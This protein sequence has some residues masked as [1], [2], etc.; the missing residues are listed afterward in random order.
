MLRITSI[1]LTI[2]FYLSISS[3]Q[4]FDID[5][6]NL[7]NSLSEPNIITG[8]LNVTT[9]VGDTV[10]LPCE[11][12][13]LGHHHVN[14]LKINGDI[15]L[16]LTVGYQQFSRNMRY[17]VARLHGNDPDRKNRIESW[18]FEIRKVNYEDQGLYQCY[19]KLNPKQ[20]LKASVYLTVKSE[21]E[22]DLDENKADALSYLSSNHKLDNP[23][24]EKLS[25]NLV[26]KVDMSPNSWIK[27]RCN[28]TGSLLLSKNGALNNKHHSNY[29]LHWYKD[30]KLIEQDSR[31]LKKWVSS[32][33]NSNYMELELFAV[34]P[35]DS[36]V[37]QCKR[38]KTILK[39]VILNVLDNSSVSCFKNI[40]F[41]YQILFSFIFYL[42]IL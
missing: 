26:E 13:N 40:N 28:A 23:R 1:L 29:D 21:T 11:V 39:N 6:D 5:T 22:K 7:S 18:N 33:D 10:M 3:V 41:I 14:W 37:Y 15:P 2:T 19:I 38:D 32:Y 31:R 8:N 12:E 34:D 35:D 9:Y 25:S 24:M 4:S 27:L 16:T 20:K 36:G 17:R 42:F 30:G